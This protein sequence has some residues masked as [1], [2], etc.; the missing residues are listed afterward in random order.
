MNGNGDSFNPLDRL[1]DLAGKAIDAK[2]SRDNFDSREPGYGVDEY[3]RVFLRGAP[4][5]PASSF[6]P[7]LLVV[8]AGVAAIALVVVLA[9]S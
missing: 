3:G 2:A 8:L 4:S 5:A 9:K 6:D 7:R 1:F